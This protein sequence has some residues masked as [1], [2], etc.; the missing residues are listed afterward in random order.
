M[1]DASPHSSHFN[2]KMFTQLHQP[3]PDMIIKQS[4]G[5]LDNHRIVFEC[6]ILLGGVELYLPSM[7]L[8]ICIPDP[9]GGYVVV[10]VW[11][12]ECPKQG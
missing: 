5:S 1:K 9:Y 10:C 4:R 6:Q 7:T 3:Q 8:N 2:R 12:R 11:E